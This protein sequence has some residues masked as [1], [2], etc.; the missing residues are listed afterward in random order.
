MTPA[1]QTGAE[2]FRPLIHPLIFYF[3]GKRGEDFIFLIFSA[4]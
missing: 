4:K 1:D 3:F 2:V